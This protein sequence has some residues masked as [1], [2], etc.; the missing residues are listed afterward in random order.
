MKTLTAI[1]ALKS[2]ITLTEDLKKLEAAGDVGRF[3]LV[4]E[5]HDKGIEERVNA[6]IDRRTSSRSFMGFLTNAAAKELAQA[7]AEV[8]AE[9]LAPIPVEPAPTANV[10]PLRAAE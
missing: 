1:E 7:K 6:L 10:A 5:H 2:A 9:C 4:F 8:A 3:R